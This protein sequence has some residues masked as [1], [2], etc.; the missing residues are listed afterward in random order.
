MWTQHVSG[1]VLCDKGSVENHSV[2]SRGHCKELS[3]SSMGREK[4]VLIESRCRQRQDWGLQVPLSPLLIAQACTALKQQQATRLESSSPGKCQ[5]VLL[6][7]S[8][9]AQ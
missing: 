9:Q 6:I 7:R 2:C 1:S 4:E 8:P 5:K 3:Q